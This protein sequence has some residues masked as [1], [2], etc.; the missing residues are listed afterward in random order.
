MTEEQARMLAAVH[1]AVIGEKSNGSVI[2]VGLVE[3]VARLEKW[4]LVIAASLFGGAGVG[5]FLGA[6]GWPF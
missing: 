1:R 3:R 6:R 2:S 4:K 5:N